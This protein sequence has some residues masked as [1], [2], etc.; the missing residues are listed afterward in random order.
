MTGPGPGAGRGA[1]RRRPWSRI[2]LRAR[3][4][5]AFGLV[6]VLVTGV[7]SLATWGLASDYLTGR[8]EVAGRSQVSVDAVL[9]DAAGRSPGIDVPP[10]LA[11]LA[12]TPGASVL[13]RTDGRWT[14]SGEPVDPAILPPALVDAPDRRVAVARLRVNGRRVLAAAAPVGSDGLLVELGPLAELDSTLRYLAF[15][16]GTTTALSALLGVALGWWA[17]GRALRP[18]HELSAAAGRV[19]AGDLDQRLPEDDDPD[20]APLAA[21]FNRTTAD[22]QRRVRRDARFAGDVSHELRSPLTTLVAAADVLRRRRSEMPEPA[23]QAVDLLDADLTRFSRLVTDLLEISRQEEEPHA[24]DLETVDLDALLRAVAAERFAEASV[25]GPGPGPAATVVRGDRRRLR[26]VLVNLGENAEIHGGGLVRLATSSAGGVVRWEVDD[27]GPGVPPELREQIFER[28]DRGGLAGDRT[29]TPGS[30]LGLAVVAGHVRRHHG[31]VRMTARPGG[32]AR[33]VV[34]IP[35]AAADA[36]GS[37]A[38][39]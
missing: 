9:A 39:A 36:A 37:D 31:A 15:V 19:A 21:T 32:G 30:G 3:V 27:A 26:Q 38:G 20:L 29:A 4:A 14:A 33:A 24:E 5:V 28:L 25:E 18:V 35:R 13:L 16:L 6:T 1:R 8:R 2:G 12:G 10:L 7:L 22:L 17:G 11:G 23:R 34:E